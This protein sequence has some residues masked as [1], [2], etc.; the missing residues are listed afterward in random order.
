MAR[1]ILMLSVIT[2]LMAMTVQMSFAGPTLREESVCDFLEGIAYGLCNAYCEVLDCHS[3]N[4]MASDN[5]CDEVL[6]SFL[7]KSGGELPHKRQDKLL[8]VCN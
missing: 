4:P 1:W 6:G 8:M 7:A 5:V 2:A 3:G